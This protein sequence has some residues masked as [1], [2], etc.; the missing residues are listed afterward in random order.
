[1]AYLSPLF[2]QRPD[3]QIKV[4]CSKCQ[5]EILCKAPPSHCPVCKF[6]FESF[7]QLTTDERKG[8][9]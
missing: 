1:M 4:I 5:S 3:E 8:P 2:T 7:K 9:K 6:K